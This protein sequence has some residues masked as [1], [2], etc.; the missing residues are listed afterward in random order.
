MESFRS[1]LRK[2]ADAERE[3]EDD[4][5]GDPPEEDDRNDNQLEA[6]RLSLS[7]EN[8]YEHVPIVPCFSG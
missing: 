1:M 7:T 5:G 4:Y 8:E 6:T 3:V 2:L